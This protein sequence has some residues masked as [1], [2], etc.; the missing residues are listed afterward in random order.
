M[1]FGF[2]VRL[3]K[4]SLTLPLWGGWVGVSLD[5]RPKYSKCKYGKIL[6]LEREV[7]Q[8]LTDGE[9]NQYT[10]NHDSFILEQLSLC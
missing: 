3:E 5:R 2:V 9:S 1:V 10:V 4:I 6:S 7:F 8:I